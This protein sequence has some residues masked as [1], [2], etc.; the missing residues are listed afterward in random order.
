MQ[1]SKV[2][3]G[4][5]NQRFPVVAGGFEQLE[6]THHVG[7]D[8]CFRANDRTVDV[9]LR[10]EVDDCLRLVAR[11]QVGDERCILNPTMREYVFIAVLDRAQVPGLPA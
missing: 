3:V 9:A 1:K 10:R 8:E 11:E 2:L 7:H 6:R 5:A 4:V